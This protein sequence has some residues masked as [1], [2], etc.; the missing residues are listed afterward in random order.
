MVPKRPD[1][2]ARLSQ[3]EPVIHESLAS[4]A[5]IVRFPVSETI[6]KP[7]HTLLIGINAAEKARFSGALAKAGHSATVV[8]GLDIQGALAVLSADHEV[9]IDLVAVR[10]HTS[11]TSN[12]LGVACELVR[13]IRLADRR[14]RVLFLCQNFSE[15]LDRKTRNVAPDNSSLC[16][17][18]DQISIENAFTYIHGDLIDPPSPVGPYMPVET[19]IGMTHVLIV[20]P[21]SERTKIEQAMGSPIPFLDTI[22]HVETAEQ[23][24]Q[25]IRALP[26][27]GTHLKLVIQLPPDEACALIDSIQS[28]VPAY[29]T[30]VLMPERT[31]RIDALMDDIGLHVATISPDGAIS[32]SLRD[33]MARVPDVIEY[34]EQ[35]ELE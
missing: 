30:I 15:E 32:G 26:E 13:A 24:R 25:M 9:K 27:L 6:R 20:A 5:A 18:D 22:L 16:F 10:I 11:D 17:S 19:V 7:H 35:L 34:G 28:I 31:S 12:T 1:L 3:R 8:D 4:G 2:K 21:G 33:F 14:I 23:A 29:Q